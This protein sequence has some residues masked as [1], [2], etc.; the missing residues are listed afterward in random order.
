[1]LVLRWL[2]LAASLVM[3]A[4][5]GCAAPRRA[6]PPEDLPAEVLAA[7][8]KPAPGGARFSDDGRAIEI[9]DGVST[10]RLDPIDR[11]PLEDAASPRETLR[12]ATRE[13]LEDVAHVEPADAAAAAAS[14]LYSDDES[15]AIVRAD[16]DLHVKRRDCDSLERLTDSTADE[17]DPAISPDGRWVVFRRD[18]ELHLL[19]L[20]TR[21]E[22]ALVA[23]DAPAASHGRLDWVYQEEIFGRDQWSA[24]WWS[25]DSCRLAWLALDDSE[26]PHSTLL[27]HTTTT[28]RTEVY[29]YPH[30]GEPNPLP[31]LWWCEVEGEPE[32]I[33]I[34]HAPSE[35]LIV[36]VGWGPAAGEVIFQVQDRTQRWVELY[37][38]DTAGGERE[39]RAPEGARPRLILREES[40]TWV[41]RPPQP[42]WL[43][44]GS[45]LWL[46]ARDGT[47]QLYRFAGDGTLIAQPT[48]GRYDI[49][50]VLR[51]DGERGLVWFSAIEGSP[52]GTQLYRLALDGGE[53]RRATDGR[54][55][56]RVEF[57]RDG[58]LFLDHFSSLESPPET[59][60]YRVD[61][62]GVRLAD[63]VIPAQEAPRPRPAGAFEPLRI[64]AR[65]GVPL[66]ALLRRPS[67]LGDGR[68]SPVLLRVY[69]GPDAPIARDRWHDSRFDDFLAEQGIA[70]FLVNNRSAS[71]R[72]KRATEACYRRFG[73]GELADIE[74]A[75]RWLVSEPWVD[76]DR[77]AITGHSFGGFVTAYALTHSTLFRLGI[78]ESGVYDWRLYDSIYTERYM[79]TP[80]ENPEGYRDSSC[81]E[82]ARNLAGH[83]LLIHGALDDNVHVHNLHC[84][85]TA[86]TAADKSIETMVYPAAR[87]GLGAEH[88]HNLDL[89]WDVLRRVL[90]EEPAGDRQ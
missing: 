75:V 32:R 10:R 58:S 44:D 35:I 59:R 40:A 71:G 73:R 6:P 56:H 18:G 77:I 5:A 42:W 36:Q 30:P 28:L 51:F 15:F 66:D 68:R 14:A 3:I 43:D 47:R 64:P 89:Q 87:H 37:R 38:Y 7:P 29:P 90:L 67:P 74:D 49:E 79:G 21:S 62:L 1:M 78:A 54:G 83:L 46:S 70:L 22:R 86:L 17:E 65:D 26:V 34:P 50:E 25:P 53:P 61:D 76:P 23:A 57:H 48:R 41:D 4:G 80:A 72:G 11:T 63:I 24:R 8:R 19:D 85:A 81:V 16:H 39:T 84:F 13:L 20:E 2:T 33:P 12:A 27:D 82:A 31:S 55:T 52:P 9:R 45:F 69:G 60:L 88:R